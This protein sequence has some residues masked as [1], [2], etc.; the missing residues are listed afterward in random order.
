MDDRLEFW[1]QRRPETQR[2][3]LHFL[4]HFQDIFA[5]IRG[6]FVHQFV[7]EHSQTPDVQFVGLLLAA[8]DF[9]GQILLSAAESV[10]LGVAAEGGAEAEVAEL[11][12]V[13]SVDQN[14]FGFDIS[15]DHP[16]LVEIRHSRGGLP[17]YFDDLF[18]SQN[19]L[20]DHVEEVPLFNVLE[21]QEEAVAELESVVQ[22]DDVWV[23]E[24]LVDLYFSLER[25]TLVGLDVS[26][27]DLINPQ[28]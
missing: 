25:E 12:V 14:I 5:I 18:V 13:V 17:E 23:A 19:P 27:V 7:E 8:D 20:F 15:M 21:D 16:P 2:L 24:L 1:V 22:A 11:E 3:G 6:L 10:P 26:Q 28:P 4:G 9:G